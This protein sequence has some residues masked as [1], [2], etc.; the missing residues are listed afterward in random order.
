[1]TTCTETCVAGRL[2]LEIVW[3][4]DGIASLHLAWADGREPSLATDTGRAMQAAMTRYVAG[5]AV[6]WP[7]LPLRRQ[8]L[9]PFARKVLDALAAVPHGQ[10]VSYGWLAARAG[11]PRA[12]RAVGRVM[13]QNRFPLVIPCHRV[14]ASDGGIGGF[15]PGLEMKR[16]MLA[17]E[18]A[19]SDKLEE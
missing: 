4:G 14:I 9:P 13:A 12:A 11:N 2:A 10:L 7:D 15:G 6:T 3:D 5:E 1:M 16:Y 17:C 19:M 8:G 18:G